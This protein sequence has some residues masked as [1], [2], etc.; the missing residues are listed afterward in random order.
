MARPLNINY[1]DYSIATKSLDIFFAGCF[2]D[3]HDCCNPELMDFNNGTDFVEWLPKI[4]KYLKD[5]DSLIENI[6]LVGGSPNHQDAEQMEIFLEGLKRRCHESIKI[7]VFCGEDVLDQVQPVFKK[8]CD[9]VKVGAY[10]PELTC[11]NN[12]QYG[13]KLATEN[14]KILKK[15]EGF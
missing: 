4:E 14:Q 9:F 5:Y 11:D 7:F 3:C 1:I 6:F 13:I 15:G 2:N 8:Y 10:R 12:I